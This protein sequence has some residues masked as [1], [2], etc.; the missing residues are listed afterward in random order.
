[1]EHDQFMAH[2]LRGI[3]IWMKKDESHR[4]ANIGLEF[5]AK[6]LSSLRCDDPDVITHPILKSTF[7]YLLKTI[8]L[9]INVRFRIC[10]FVNMLLASMSSEA[11]IDDDIFDEI[12]KYM[13]ERMKDLSPTVRVQAVYA[14]QRL[15]IPENPDDCVVRIYSYHLSNDPSAHVRQAVLKSIGRNALTVPIILERLWDVD[16]RV[17]RRTYLQMSSHPVKSYKVAQRLQLLEQGLN[18]HSE[19]VRKITHS[20]LLPQWLQS[21]NKQ[22]LSL[23]SA[24]KLDANQEELQRFVKI[25]KKALFSLF[26]NDSIDELLSQLPLSNTG[27]Y[28][29]CIPF[30]KLTVEMVVYWL[31]MVEYIQ[32]TDA[33][34][35][36]E[37]EQLLQ[38]ICELS[39]FCEYLTKYI[40]YIRESASDDPESWETQENQY[41]L[42][43]LI[44]ILL[45]FDLGDE[46]GRQ[47]LNTFVSKVLSSQL[48]GENI[49]KKLVHCVENLITDLDA[50]L[51]YFI[52]IIRSIIDPSSSIDVSDPSIAALLESI[53]DP[54]TKVKIGH[55]KLQIMDLREQEIELTKNRNFA[56][57]DSVTEELAGCNEE[58][59][60]LLSTYSDSTATLPATSELTTLNSKK[61]SKEWNLHCL[62]IFFFAVCSKQTTALNPNMFKLYED[63][64]QRHMKSQHMEIRDRALKC[65]ITCSMLYEHLAKDVHEELYQQ[66]VRHHQ[67]RLWTTAVNGICEMFDRYGIDFFTIDL[68]AEKPDGSKTKKTRQLY[69]ATL[70]QDEAEESSESGKN[71]TNVMYLF[72]HLFD[73]CQEASISMALATG[74]C[75]LILGGHYETNEI[76]SKILL[77]FFTPTTCTEISQILS[78]FFETLIQRR[79][80]IV[81]QKALLPTIFTILDAPHESPLR[82]I[83]PDHVIKF[84]INSTV[85]TATDT[86]AHIH[87]EVARTFLQRMVEQLSN[88]DVLKLLSKELQTLDISTEQSVRDELKELAHKL[89]AESI[90]D[91]KIEG[92]IKVFIEMLSGNLSKRDNAAGN[93]DEYCSDEDGA[94]NENDFA[95]DATK[96]DQTISDA[97]PKDT[98]E[99]AEDAADDAVEDVLDKS[100]VSSVESKDG[101][102]EKVA[103]I[104][105]SLEISK[106]I[107]ESDQVRLNV[108]FLEN[109]PFIRRYFLLIY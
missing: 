79:K 73:T 17:R 68:D 31:S 94:N 86:N 107:N 75:R 105:S 89:L 32:E 82:E 87:T 81:L 63:F 40:N 12:L 92:Y 109:E 91:S 10:Q 62:E 16:D 23:I 5:L 37:D 45:R 34:E 25:T 24:L 18:D 38:V 28:T 106:E 43:L 35:E 46:I 77:K 50:R 80:Q 21:Y 13:S 69:N 52:D 26:K 54:E 39:T 70:E 78:V 65:G 84:V 30:E 96:R 76:M 99:A 47:N 44:E 22:Y 93:G 9:Q 71:S 58:F 4:Y 48:L 53:T 59:V 29:K 20:V 42:H 61:V 108:D 51:Q 19:P 33:N 67:P 103:E 3:R 14:L 57:L 49:I 83:K 66:F 1:M 36:D 100:A 98:N 55:L 27:D 90:N 102:E 11:N 7:E 8:S 88:K 64:V 97:T 101:D 6:Y 95:A 2:F 85:Q 56:R 41:K 60:S 74:F 15:Q 104:S 72:A